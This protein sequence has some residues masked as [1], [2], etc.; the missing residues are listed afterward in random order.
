MGGY[1]W[2]CIFP[3]TQS[4]ISASLAW[5]SLHQPSL[6]RCYPCCFQPARTHNSLLFPTIGGGE[7]GWAESPSLEWTVWVTHLEMWATPM[8]CHTTGSCPVSRLAC[9]Q[10]RWPPCLGPIL[11]PLPQLPHLLCFLPFEGDSDVWAGSQLISQ[12]PL[13]FVK[14][15]FFF[16]F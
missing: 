9:G 16:F 3:A 15:P 13:C 12:S 4:T 2:S 14:I 8:S 6:E 7:P 1:T 10:I 5:S 11:H